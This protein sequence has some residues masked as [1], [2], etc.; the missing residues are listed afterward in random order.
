MTAPSGMDRRT[1]L[2]LTGLA[3]TGLVL[4]FDAHGALALDGQ[5]EFAPNGFLRIAPDGSTTLWSTKAEVG[6]GVSTALPMIV[7][8][9]LDADWTRVR[10]EYAPIDPKRYGNQDTGGSYSVR[11]SWKPL[12]RAGAAARAML[13]AAAAARWGVPVTECRTEPGAVVH[14]PTSRRLGY[15]ELA[16]DA[17]KQPVPQEP[18]LKTPEQRRLFGTRIARVDL[19]AKVDGSARYSLDVRVPGMLF[20]SIERCPTHG[21]KVARVDGA[22]ALALPGV[23]HVVPLERGVAVVADDTWT[24]MQARAALAITWDHGPLAGLDRAGI[25]ARFDADASREGVKHRADG[26]FAA[27]LARAERTLEADYHV[28]YVAHAPMEP[29]N[30]TAHVQGDRCRLWSPVQL[31]SWAIPAVAGALGIPAAN[32]TLERPFVGGAFGRRLYHDYAIEAALV[33][34]ALQ[35]PVQV[36]WTREDDMRGGFYRPA[37]RH[38]LTAGLSG[39]RLTAFRHRVIA[40]SISLQ[41]VPDEV[42]DG[43]DENISDGLVD[44]PYA[45][46]DYR[47]EHVQSDPGVPALWW[48]SVWSSQNPF[49]S[50]GFLDE[51]AV[52]AGADP[53]AFRLALLAKQPRH[54]GVLRL[55][56]EQAGWGRKL[57]K[58]R[59]MGI[60]M[61][62]SFGSFAAMVAEVSVVKG[63]PRVHRAVIALDCGTVVD[64]DTV[65][66]QL[67]GAVVFGLSAAL[68]SR[69]TIEH[70]ATVE[71]NFDGHRILRLPE[72]PVVEVHLVPSAEPP[73]GVGEPG[74]PVVAPAVA[75]ALFAATGKR[76]RRMPFV[77]GPV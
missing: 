51:C 73:G 10:V 77:E 42:K 9:E 76:W 70:G 36:V 68:Y 34:K 66:A 55:V 27:A 74:V 18:T 39:G 75:N 37:S 69:I 25:E 38:R 64:P 5:A 12:R 20:A 58:G 60:A 31:P 40:P 30:T 1:F 59:G 33:S 32:V 4:G 45:V 46:S 22:R 35:L 57:P 6:Q 29:Q 43:V 65:R 50:E 71:S 61:H 48:R 72:T 63:E 7:A 53:L 19:P 8:E 28:P 16:E 44:W 26:D 11:G 41:L 21:G 47:A 14:E 3:A 15:G 62:A 67:E 54:A 24:A 52:A 56:A 49:G 17:A 13:I 2:W 23:R